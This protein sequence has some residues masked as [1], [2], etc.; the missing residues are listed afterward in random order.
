MD[1][2]C[3]T[4]SKIPIRHWAELSEHDRHQYNE[5]RLFFRQQQKD[6]LRERRTSPFTGEIIAILA[7]TDQKT[8]GRDHRCIVSGIAGA[9]P[10]VA[11]NTQQFKHFIGRCKSS[12]NSGFQQIGYDVVRNRAKARESIWSIIPELR[13]E[14]GFIRQW[15]VRSAGDACHMCFFSSY[16]P[17]RLPVLVP[18]DFIDERKAPIVAEPIRAAPQ[19]VTEPIRFTRPAMPEPLP[20]PKVGFDFCFVESDNDLFGDMQPSFSVG[21]LSEMERPFDLHFDQMPPAIDPPSW[22]GEASWNG[23]AQ[24]QRSQSVDLRMTRL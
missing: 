1:S 9:G 7:F 21:F 23:K 4:D 13:A 22:L 24:M 11:V 14:P 6:C 18:E 12:I 20:P 8:P 16:I 5:L 15:T 19:I 3:P 2:L 17:P 10:F